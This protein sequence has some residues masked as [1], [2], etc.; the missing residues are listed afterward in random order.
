[1]QFLGK[2]SEK[3]L[4]GVHV[5]THS[6]NNKAIDMYKKIGFI[7]YKPEDELRPQDVHLIYLF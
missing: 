5:Y 7:P 3:G 2:A 4:R 6:T 1:M